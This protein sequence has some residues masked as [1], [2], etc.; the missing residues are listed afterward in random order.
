MN[1]NSLTHDEQ[2]LLRWENEGGCLGVR[3][4]TSRTWH[5]VNRKITAY[6]GREAAFRTV[7][8]QQ[9]PRSANATLVTFTGCS[10]AVA[11]SK[12]IQ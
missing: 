7:N 9:R 10:R 3:Q 5:S 11:G 8:S 1:S 12:D 6:K 2:A 4:Q